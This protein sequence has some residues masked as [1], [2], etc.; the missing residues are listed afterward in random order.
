MNLTIKA[1]CRTDD[2]GQSVEFDAAQWFEQASD[3][4]ILALDRCSWGDDYCP[5]V[6]QVATFFK[7][8]NPQIKGLFDYLANINKSGRKT[9]KIGFEVSIDPDAAC[10][11]IKKHRPHL[12]KQL[13]SYD[14]EYEL[15]SFI[16]DFVEQLDASPGLV[17]SDEEDVAQQIPV[18][19]LFIHEHFPEGFSQE[20]H[21]HLLSLAKRMN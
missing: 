21:Q 5:D 11:W 2:Y 9:K 8:R 20:E 15:K 19:L 18:L 17:I 13:Q 12:A 14:T 16:D 6:D 4:A 3:K 7:E 1:E 10:N